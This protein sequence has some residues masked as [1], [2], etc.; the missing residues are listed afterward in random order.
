MANLGPEVNRN[1]DQYQLAAVK[2][3]LEGI[4]HRLEIPSV[5]LETAFLGDLDGDI[6]STFSLSIAFRTRTSNG[7]GGRGR[8]RYSLGLSLQ[9]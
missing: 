1:V 8:L 4:T 9:A 7:R 5:I 3:R 6:G 2:W